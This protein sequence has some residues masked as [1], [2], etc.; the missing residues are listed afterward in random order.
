MTTGT[1]DTT[2]TKRA[3][4]ANTTNTT[5]TAVRAHPKGSKKVITEN[6]DEHGDDDG[7]KGR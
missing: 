2:N 4:R 3:K 1:T 5:K 7:E 6:N